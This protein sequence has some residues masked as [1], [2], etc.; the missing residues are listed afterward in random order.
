[1]LTELST[2]GQEEE[3]EEKRF[4][5]LGGPSNTSFFFGKVQVGT[6]LPVCLI[7]I[8]RMMCIC[9]MLH[10]FVHS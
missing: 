3:E 1:M 4:V 5:V 2:E 9:E 8:V 7:Q 6:I 10:V